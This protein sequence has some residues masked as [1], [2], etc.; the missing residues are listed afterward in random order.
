M[1][2]GDKMIKQNKNGIEYYVFENLTK[3]NV[4]HG[5]PNRKNGFSV[6][7]FSSL[8]FSYSVG[9]DSENL[10]KNYEKLFETFEIENHAKAKQTH[11]NHIQVVAKENNI[12]FFEDID[13][14]VSDDDITLIT[15]HADC[16]SIFI[17]DTKKDVF[18]ILHSGWVGTSKN[19]IGEALKIL[20][21]EFDSNPKDIL[22]GIGPSICKNCFEVDIDVATIFENLGYNEFISIDEKRSKYLIDLKSIIKKQVLDFD[23]PIENIEVSDLC[24][25]CD[26]TEFFSHR[27]D[28]IKRGGH[29]GFIKKRK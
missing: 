27:R 16:G 28:G 8:N 19:I 9:D 25:K 18:A 20:I 7:E 1:A 12:D 22:V 21:N 23:V 6:N 3:A 29:L 15:Y 14:F 17:Y 24:T 26:E 2:M 5:F 11:S 10:K 4:T 13:G